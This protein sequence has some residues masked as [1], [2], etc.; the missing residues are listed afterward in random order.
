MNRYLHVKPLGDGTY[1]SVTLA[2][3]KETGEEVAIKLM[4]KKFFSW[5][6][7]M[8]LREIKALKKLS[9]P[10]LVKLKEVIREN[11]QLHMIFEFLN[12]N[13]YE[14]MKGR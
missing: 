4:K 2:R 8:Q 11:D 6:E 10:N 12:E 7:C 14:L 13:L 3:N 5:N 9:H 1:G